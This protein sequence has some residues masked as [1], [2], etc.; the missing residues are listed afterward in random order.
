[1]AFHRQRVAALAGVMAGAAREAAAE[2]DT[3]AS[4]GQPVD[5]GEEMMRLTR[6]VVVRALLG[7]D[8]GPYTATIDDAWTIINERVAE[9]FWSLGLT[10]WMHPARTRRF[11]HARAVLRGAVDADVDARRGDRRDDDRRAAARRGD[12]VSA[13]RSGDDVAGVDVDLVSVV[14]ARERAAAARRGDRSPARWTS[15]RVRRS[16][17]PA[18]HADGDRRSDAPLPAGVGL[19]AAGARRR[20]PRRISP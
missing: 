5:I 10:D 13:G 15:T 19:L 16:R 11:E 9:S 14:A 4:G 6:T 8:L 2:W 17:E 18:V 7:G 3:L 12:D 1:P 20:P